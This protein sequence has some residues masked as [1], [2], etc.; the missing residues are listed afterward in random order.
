MTRG[1]RFT[2]GTLLAVLSTVG[3]PAGDAGAN[4]AVQREIQGRVESVDPASGRLVIVREF[5]GRTW[6]VELTAAPGSK[7]YSCSTE[8][9]G[10][11]RLQVGMPL[12]V[13]Y[14]VVGAE[15]I[16]NAIVLE[17]GR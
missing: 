15:G 6:R 7:V 8:Q 5:R 12:S 1:M 2:M 13:F 9:G 14:E 11:D 17:P 4:G 16:A 10:L 3:A